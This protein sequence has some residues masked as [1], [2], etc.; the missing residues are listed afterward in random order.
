MNL[1]NIKLHQLRCL[2]EVAK[3]GNFSEAAL[4][5][6]VSQSAVSHAI[7]ALEAELGIILFSRGRHGATL[8]PAGER[9]VS[10]A[11]D[12]LR[13]LENIGKEATLTK[14]LQGGQVRIAAF[15]S[16]ATH[17][18]PRVIAQFQK[19][20][21]AIAVILRD[22]QDCQEIE[23]A[24]RTGQVDV[25]ITLLPTPRE[26][27]SW[28][29]MRDEY[30]VLLPP[31][32]S[33]SNDP[34]TWEQLTTY[35]LILPTENDSCRGLI[36]EYCD[37]L[38]KSLNPTYEVRE[39]STT[40]S[41]VEQGLGMTIIARL[42]AE[43]IPAKLQIKQLPEPLERVMGVV[44]LAEAL[45]PPAVYAFINQLQ[46]VQRSSTLEKLPVKAR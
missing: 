33:I 26:F 3:F 34:L 19:N 13:S 15:R 6:G 21:P 39:D 8:T 1:E 38:G 37:R 30:V 44:T 32:W 16:A 24:L 23:S 46:E 5:L 14:G 12:M 45:H 11:E 20:F 4:H 43:P 40:M 10:H 28:E 35:P 36:S 17:L 25:A 7:A 22:L 42:A 2:I 27:E 41:M 9:V 18:L 31:D 29:L